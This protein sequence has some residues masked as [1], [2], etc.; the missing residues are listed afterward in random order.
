[1]TKPSDFYNAVV[2]AMNYLD[3]RLPF[4]SHV[5]L[6]GLANGSYLYGLLSD[7]IH[8]LGRLKNDVTYADF[9]TYL[10]CLQIS[11]CNGWMSTNET[12]R[13]LTTQYAQM[14]SGL[15]KNI[16]E[17]LTFKNFDMD[18]IDFPLTQ[19]KFFVEF[20]L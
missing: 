9:Y 17:S 14:L 11:P 5:M 6:T 19:G 3:T 18:Y 16:S 15:V 4:G 20:N 13:A 7:K 1:M 2:D 8:P 12:L 10:S